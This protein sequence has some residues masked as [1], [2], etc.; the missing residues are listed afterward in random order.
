MAEEQASTES[1]DELA[2]AIA[3]VKQNPREPSRWERVEELLESAQR[4]AD[5]SELFLGVLGKRLSAEHLND[6]GQRGMR[7]YEAWFGEESKELRH[8]LSRMLQAD[9]KAEWAFERLTV[10]LTATEQWTDLLEAFDRAISAADQTSRRMRLLEEAA[11][12]A[13]DFAKLPERAIGYMSKLHALDPDNATLAAALERLLER[14]ERW[15]DL[16]ALWR[17]R[18]PLQSPKQ[19]RESRLRI[20]DVYLERL[21]GYA[22]ALEQVK[23]V[24][25]EVPD[26]PGAYAALERVLPAERAGAAERREAHQLLRQRYLDAQKPT[27]VVRVL[28][29]GLGYAEE[30]ER[31]A[32]LR[33]LVER[34]TELGDDARAMKHQ[35]ALL[36]LEPLSRERDLLRALCER[37][38]D[39]ALF[40]HALVQAAERCSEPTIAAELVLE[41]ART[42]QDALGDDAAATALYERVFRSEAPSQ[43]V[44]EAGRALIRCS[45]KAGA[46][47]TR[48]QRSG[49]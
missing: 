18:L 38:R 14:Q 30:A 4:P 48:S 7:F 32:Q 19:A 27:E 49:A 39:H 23:L 16:V 17:T 21:A 22:E 43:L 29:L 9:P 42:R 34:L 35:A 11:Q 33:E 2:S 37:T 31:R 12:I 46:K 15:A 1:A 44:A 24:L 25:A 13:K 47:R 36:A 20:A 41:A 10:A 3:L 28:E 26:S 8:W 40:A 45:S 6:I 5:V